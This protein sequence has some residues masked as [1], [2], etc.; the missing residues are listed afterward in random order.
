MKDLNYLKIKDEAKRYGISPFLHTKRKATYRKA[1]TP[2]KKS[3]LTC[4]Y[5]F[6]ITFARSD[7]RTQCQIIGADVDRNADIDFEH[8]CDFYSD[9]FKD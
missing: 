7:E 1:Q 9:L 8:I 2:D 4:E 5:R 6:K 3:C